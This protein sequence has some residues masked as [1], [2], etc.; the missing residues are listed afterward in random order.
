MYICI[1]IDI[2]IHP[3]PSWFPS[4]PPRALDSLCRIPQARVRSPDGSYHVTVEPSVF[5][6]QTS[7]ESI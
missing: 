1:Y 7:E 6:P 4:S 3:Y 2:Y 5:P